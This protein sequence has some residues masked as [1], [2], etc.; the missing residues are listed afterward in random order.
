MRVHAIAVPA[1]MLLLSFTL[2]GCSSA[3]PTGTAALSQTQSSPSALATPPAGTSPSAT[4]SG[5]PSGTSGGANPP[6]VAKPNYA[7]TAKGYATNTVN[8]YAKGSK[9]LLAAYTSNGGAV[10]FA[11]LPKT[12]MKW[13]FHKCA[14]D[15]T[16]TACEFDND[17]G[18]ELTVDIDPTY[19]GKPDAAA[20]AV[21]L[22]TT[23]PTSADALVGEFIDAWSHGN[24]YRMARLA[25]A[26]SVDIVY[27]EFGDAP[28]GWTL[29]DSALGDRTAVTIHPLPF[30]T[31]FAVFV[32]NANLGH[33]HA[34][35]AQ[36]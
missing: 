3:K 26:P 15:G 25:D 23:Y 27:S 21:V 33:P 24:K 10:S 19:L 14:P 2:A 1:T 18:D 16:N 7:T 12:N 17:N 29:S 9:A 13:H 8:A 31:E 32:D 36:A 20:S 5:T 34:M 6:S 30:G 11:N 22:V 28:S 4:Q 35:T